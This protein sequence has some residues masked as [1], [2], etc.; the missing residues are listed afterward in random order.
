MGTMNNFLKSGDAR[1]TDPEIMEAI[2]H[3]SGGDEALAERIWDAPTDEEQAAI[4]ERI[5][6]NTELTTR[7]FYW[8][9]AQYDWYG[10]PYNPAQFK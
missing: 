1:E 8:G 10:I 3:L 7:D 5:T 4:A 6:K 9:A 2:W